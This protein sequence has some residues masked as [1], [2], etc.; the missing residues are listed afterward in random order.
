[1]CVFQDPPI[2]LGMTLHHFLSMPRLPTSFHLRVKSRFSLRRRGVYAVPRSFN[3][4]CFVAV[5][6]FSAAGTSGQVNL[7]Y[8]GR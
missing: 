3:Q 2:T 7:F 1:M 8:S 5:P 4:V 6:K